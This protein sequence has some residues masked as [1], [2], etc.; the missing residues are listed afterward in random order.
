MSTMTLGARTGLRG[1]PTLLVTETRLWLRDAGTVFY[2][3]VFPTVLIVGLGLAIPGM[4]EPITDAPEPWLGM[5]PIAFYGPVALATAVAS[6]A[7]TTFPSY[8]ATFREKGVLRRLSTTPMRPQGLVLAHLVIS[9]GALLVAAC[10]AVVVG[11]IAFGLPAP[12]SAAIVLL[13]FVLCVLSMFGIGAVIAAL[14]PRATTANAFGMLIYFPMLFFAGM[15]TPG[16]VM[17]EGVA[18]VARFT[19][20]GAATQAMNAGWFTGEVPGLQLVVMAAWAAVLLPVAS[21]YFRWS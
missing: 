9:L 1:F 6:I 17:P 19:P 15:W 10:L 11:G 8:V 4:R 18:E 14:T 16:P 21:R 3:V 7:L 20:L 5:T 13:S 12:A 2:A